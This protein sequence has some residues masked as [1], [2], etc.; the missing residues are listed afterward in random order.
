MLHFNIIEA[1]GSQTK[2]FVM[3]LQALIPS[4][5]LSQVTDNTSRTTKT[6]LVFFWRVLGRVDR[7]ELL[8]S[9]NFNT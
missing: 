8:Q 1:L 6:C 2:P 7:T 4:N 5:H 3:S 9:E